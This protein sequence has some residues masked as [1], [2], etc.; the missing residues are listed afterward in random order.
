MTGEPDETKKETHIESRVEK[1]TEHFWQKIEHYYGIRFN[2]NKNKYVIT[3]AD[4]RAKSL[5]LQS[6]EIYMDLFVAGKLSEEEYRFWANELTI[7]ETYFFR[8]EGQWETIREKVIPEILRANAH[9]KNFNAISLGSSSGEEPYT[10]AMIIQY[11]FKGLPG[12]RVNIEATD[13]K[14]ELLTK[15]REG[16]YTERSVRG[17]ARELADLYLRGSMNAYTLTDDIRRMVTFYYHNILDLP[18]KLQHK[19]YDLIFCRNVI[20]YF[21]RDVAVQVINGMSSIL[22]PEGYLI[23]GHSEGHLVS[24]LQVEPHFTSSAVVYKKKKVE[25]VQPERE[26]SAWYG[27]KKKTTT[28]STNGNRS[29]AGAVKSTESP[30]PPAL[31]FPDALVEQAQKL[32]EQHQ[33]EAA[34]EKLELAVKQLPMYT[35]A[36]Y[37][38]GILYQI[39]DE[40][41]KAFKQFERVIFLD[42]NHILATFQCAMMQQQQGNPE[43]SAKLYRKILQLTQNADHEAVIDQQS[44]LTIGFLHMVCTRFLENESSQLASR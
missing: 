2:E 11:Y 41:E 9:T 42:P 18:E 6:V 4:N 24:G 14:D 37:M 23:L 32:I 38:L 13:I 7:N 20:I 15:A 36:Q 27:F 29:S 33:Y 8:D 17:V 39:L 19:Q 34:K 16:K 31:Q 35:P 44:E 43:V 3:L 12:W 28:E 21:S 40:P 22:N 30:A 1:I 5:G 26:I 25:L 10:L